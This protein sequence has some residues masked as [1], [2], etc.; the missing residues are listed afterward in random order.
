VL[1][2]AMQQGIDRG[3]LAPHD[4]QT[5][6]AALIGATAEALIGPLSTQPRPADDEALIAT[7]VSFCI[8]ALPRQESHDRHHAA[9]V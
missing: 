6:S 4:T 7:L 8:G 5:F 2:Q 3:E 1:A 9:H